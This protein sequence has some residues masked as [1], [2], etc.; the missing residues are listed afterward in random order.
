MPWK[1]HYVCP[2]EQ[3]VCMRDGSGA[4]ACGRKGCLQRCRRLGAK[5][6]GHAHGGAGKPPPPHDGRCTAVGSSLCNRGEN[7]RLKGALKDRDGARDDKEQGQCN[8]G[9]QRRAHGGTGE[10]SL[11][12]ERCAVVRRTSRGS[13]AGDKSR[14]H[15]QKAQREAEERGNIQPTVQALQ[16][17]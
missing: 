13:G 5:A 10:A 12:H 9:A 15:M 6:Q 16:S 11:F 8:R 2:R 14:H 1:L 17:A 4:H 7:E 3:G